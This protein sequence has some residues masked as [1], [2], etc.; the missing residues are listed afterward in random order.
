[1]E[2]EYQSQLTPK[3]ETPPQDPEP[4]SPGHSQ[5][6]PSS[7]APTTPQA[8]SQSQ[9]KPHS[10]SLPTPHP[11]SPP[12]VPTSTKPRTS[13]LT[14]VQRPAV[15]PIPQPQLSTQPFQP[16]LLHRPFSD[17]SRLAPEDAYYIPQSPP[18]I[19]TDNHPNKVAA[20]KAN[21]VAIAPLPIGP[22]PVIPGLKPTFSLSS[23]RRRREKERGRS[24]SRRSKGVWKK[25]LWVKQSCR[26]WCVSAGYWPY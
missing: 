11:S 14:S 24:G 2:S 18:Q 23:Q 19:R 15:P 6:Q 7:P 25:L 21:G 22:P 1:M 5:E 12:P 20:A 16:S 13:T 8:Q 3:A 17:P 4:P 9:P 10:Q 26:S